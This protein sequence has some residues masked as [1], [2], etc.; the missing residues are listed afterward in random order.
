MTKWNHARI[1]AALQAI[2][3]ALG[4]GDAEGDIRP[5][6]LR[7]ASRRLREERAILELRAATKAFDKRGRK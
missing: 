3:V 5:A 4:E 1:G 7:A 6:D 2:G